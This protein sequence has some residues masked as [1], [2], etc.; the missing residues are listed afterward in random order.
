MQMQDH[1]TSPAENQLLNTLRGFEH[2]VCYQLPDK[3]PLKTNGERASITD[4]STWSTYEAASAVGGGVG[5][6]ITRPLGI[7]CI[8]VDVKE[9][10]ELNE[11]QKLV[12]RTFQNTYIETS[13]SG[14][15]FHIWCRGTVETVKHSDIGIEV[16]SGERYMTVTLAPV[17]NAPLLPL[18]THLDVL[19]AKIRPERHSGQVEAQDCQETRTDEQIL[20][21]V[22]SNKRFGNL[23]SGW[24]KQL[25]CKSQSDADWELCCIFMEHGAT[26]EQAWNLFRRSQLGKRTKAERDDYKARTIAKARGNVMSKPQTN[27]TNVPQIAVIETGLVPTTDNGFAKIQFADTKKPM[28]GVEWLWYERLRKDA[29]N[30]LA[31][32]KATG[33]STIA[34]HF[35]AVVSRGDFWPFHTAHDEDELTAE[36]GKVIIWSGEDGIYSTIIPRLKAMGANFDN[37][38]IVENVIGIGPDRAF[39]PAQDM[40]LI[41]AAIKELSGQCALLIIDP[42]VSIVDGKNNDTNDVRNA[43]SKLKELSDKYK[44]GILGITHFAKNSATRNSLDRIL[45]SGAWT[46][47]PRVIWIALVDDDEDV[48]KLIRQSNNDGPIGGGYIYEID[49]QEFPNPNPH[50]RRGKPIKATKINWIAQIDHSMNPQEIVDRAEGIIKDSSKPTAKARASKWVVDYLRDGNQHPY[51]EI[52]EEAKKQQ[53]SKS[54]LTRVYNEMLDTGI[55]LVNK[56]TKPGER[57]SFW[58]LTTPAKIDVP[59]SQSPVAMPTLHSSP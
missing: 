34:Y 40:P 3:A 37:I 16:Y 27:K 46:Q 30:L 47:F 59:W 56:N 50:D 11:F 21:A 8:D 2:W 6:V 23:W 10:E 12:L 7:T 26:N 1:G 28:Q 44:V 45:G 39:N 25:G 20:S 35:A 31:G 58:Q 41:E 14:R 4:A 55:L 42:I 22:Q 33:K 43:L 57:S 53:I 13:P 49:I 38:Q 51:A 17:V 52:L 29:I 19:V 54:T 36:V 32:A 18:Q 9:G 24:W 48:R 15:G 5:F